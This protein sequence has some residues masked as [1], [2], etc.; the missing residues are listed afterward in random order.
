[1]IVDGDGHELH[2]AC[3]GNLCI[4][5]SWPGQMRTVFGDHERFIQTYFSTFKGLYF[6]G[7]GAK[8]D[9]DEVLTG[10]PACVDDV[11]N[12]SGHRMG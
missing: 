5:D 1:M 8:R 12:V 4:A 6:T 2:G 11:I 9:E 10:S 7:D 3:E